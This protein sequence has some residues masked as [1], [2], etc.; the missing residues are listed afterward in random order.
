MKELKADKKIQWW[1]ATTIVNFATVYH[2][3]INLHPYKDFNNL[4]SS[5]LLSV[6]HFFRENL[7]GNIPTTL[8]KS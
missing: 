5:K 3:G 6:V 4:I 8:I 1:K 7:H 2:E